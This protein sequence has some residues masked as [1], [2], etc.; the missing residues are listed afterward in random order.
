MLCVVA[1]PAP[2]GATVGPRPYMVVYDAPPDGTFPVQRETAQRERRYGF[3]SIVRFRHTIDGFAARLTAREARALRADPEV[4]LVQPDRRLT[5]A[6]VPLAAGEVVPTGV[7]RIGAYVAGA[8]VHPAS[9]SAVAVLDTGIDL[10]HPDLAARAGTD[11]IQ[12]GTTPE[13]DAADSHGTHVAGVIGARNNGAGLVGVAPGTELYAVKVLNAAG[14]GY[15]HEIVCGLEWVTANAKQFGIRVANMSFSREIQDAALHLAVQRSVASG[16]VYVAAAGNFD[17]NGIDL[18]IP[19]GYPE[20]LTVTAMADTD[21]APGGRGPEC[22]GHADDTA[23]TFSSVVKREQDGA[24]VIA[25]PGVCITSTARG[26]GQG[27]V[28]GTSFAAPHVAGVAALCMGDPGR[29]GPCADMTPAEVVQQVRADAVARATPQTG[30]AGDPFAPVGGYYGHL[31][32]AADPTARRIP[33]R[34]PPP[35][36]VTVSAPSQLDTTLQVLALRIARRQDVD[37]LTVSARLAEPGTVTATARVRLGAGA[38]RTFVSRV[39]SASVR[40]NETRRLRVPLRRSA[41]KR[42]KDAL[43]RGARVRARVRMTVFDPAGNARSKSL[44]VELRR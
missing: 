28:S 9:A 40:P 15:V 33:A 17:G 26:G 4:A 23:A 18:A 44:R 16:V 25:A 35:L 36:P 30:F 1:S 8:G 12:P 41:V 7:E 31:V 6:R 11:C 5:A 37:R 3:E 29:P 19:A 21:G 14:D 38:S 42:I 39:A 34:P 13:D 24:H 22:Y 27:T 32:S 10:G 2:T 43:R 20:V